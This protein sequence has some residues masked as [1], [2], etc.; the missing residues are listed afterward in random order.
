MVTT[1]TP[2]GSPESGHPRREG[3]RGGRPGRIDLEPEVDPEKYLADAARRSGKIVT[4][5]TRGTKSARR[6]H[7]PCPKSWRVLP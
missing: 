3:R 6:V 5:Y 1:M 2:Y 4:L 7:G